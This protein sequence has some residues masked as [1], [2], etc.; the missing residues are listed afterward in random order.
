MSNTV[1]EKL[2]KMNDDLARRIKILNDKKTK[3]N[4]LLLEA[5]ASHEKETEARAHM[6]RV[7]GN[8][9]IQ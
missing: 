7:F 3:I 8:R 1:Y 4:G 2:M 9:K 6:E 5:K